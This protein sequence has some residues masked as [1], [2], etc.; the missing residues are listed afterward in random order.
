[1]AA[2]RRK[3]RM[4]PYLPIET[5]WKAEGKKIERKKKN[6]FQNG[7]H[8]AQTEVTASPIDGRVARTFLSACHFSQR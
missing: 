1:M 5:F 8:G 2:I 3:S 6:D 4:P 7:K